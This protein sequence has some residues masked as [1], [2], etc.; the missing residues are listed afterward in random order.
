M[1]DVYTAATIQAVTGVEPATLRKWVERGH[2]TKL[3][4]DA[5]D[6]DSVI[7]Y[8][9]LVTLAVDVRDDRGRFAG[10]APSPGLSTACG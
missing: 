1:M 10:R 2:V 3:G 5:Y 9:R 8:W 7:A 6:G 4:R